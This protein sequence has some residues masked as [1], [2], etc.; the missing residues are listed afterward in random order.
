MVVADLDDDI[1][2]ARLGNLGS[3]DAE[4]ASLLARVSH[5][6]LLPSRELSERSRGTEAATIHRMIRPGKRA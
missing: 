6:G 4:G 3:V 1:A 2:V 5:T